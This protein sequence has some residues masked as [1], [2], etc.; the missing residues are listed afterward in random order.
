MLNYDDVIAVALTLL[1]NMH[2]LNLTKD[3][4]T[5]KKNKFGLNYNDY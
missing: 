3:L 5:N 1:N 2:L 4:P